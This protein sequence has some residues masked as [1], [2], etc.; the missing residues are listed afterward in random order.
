[1]ELLPLRGEGAAFTDVQGRG[2]GN[3]SSTT[4]TELVDLISSI[5]AVGQ[6]QPVLVEELTGGTR[7]LVSGERRVRAM[8]WGAIHHP[9][10]GHF[11]NVAAVVVDGPLSDEERRSWQ[12]I[13]NLAR[14]DLQPGELAAALLYERCA[15]LVARLV[16]NDVAVPADVAALDDPVT[17]FEALDKVRRQAG[18]HSVGAPWPEVIRRIGI[19]LSEA[20]ARKLVAAF[21]SMPTEISAEMDA[22]TVSLHSRAQWLKLRRGHADAAAEI[23]AALRDN[24]ETDLLTGAVTEALDHPAAPVAAIVDTAR[25]QREA[26]NEARAD[27]ARRTRH[28]HPQPGPGLG[29]GCAAGDDRTEIDPDVV[30]DV[31]RGLGR[32]LEALRAGAELS[33]YDTGSLRLHLAELDALLTPDPTATEGAAA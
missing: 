18:L 20:R 31:R 14:A 29:V 5:G 24:D 9:D 12:L 23:W 22:A 15:V 7:R 13:E 30:A 19:Q 21:R 10:N 26:A 3:A 6:L 25:T 1:L 28:P 2:W 27:T 4:P 33:R 32:L 17:R 11:A 16:A 8:R